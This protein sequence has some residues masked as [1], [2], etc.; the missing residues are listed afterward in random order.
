MQRYLMLRPFITDKSLSVRMEVAQLLA[1]IPASELRP[2]DMADLEPLFEEYLAIQ[3]DHLDMPSVH[4]Q[5]ANFWNDR[6]DSEKATAALEEALRLNPELEP[7]IVNLVDI[8][9]RDGKNDEASALLSSAIDRIPDSGSLW[10]SQGLHLIRLGQTDKAIVS[11]KRAAELENEG[12]RHRYVYA[13]ALN[14]TGSGPEAM[15]IL[16]D[17]NRSLPGQPDVLNALL[18]FA[19]DSGDRQRY[20]RYRSELVALMQAT[21]QR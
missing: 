20:E 17:L 9:R 14:D 15:S 13:I 19:R 2:Q 11:L 8:L 3:S 4:L 7:A 16:E 6:D 5:L 12:S 10:F 18:A 1:A 21:G